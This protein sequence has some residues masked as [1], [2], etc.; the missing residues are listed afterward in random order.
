MKT[1]MR[2]HMLIVGSIALALGANIVAIP[3][4][5]DARGIVRHH[6]G[7]AGG[8]ARRGRFARSGRRAGGRLHGGGF[9]G[10]GGEDYYGYCGPIQLT[11]GLC[12]PYGY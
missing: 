7:Q 12:G 4:V 6:G 2:K 8:H 10:V 9:G 11:L 3:S 1:Y 5:A